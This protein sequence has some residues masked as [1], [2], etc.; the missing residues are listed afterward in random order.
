MAMRIGEMMVIVRAQDFASRTLRRVGAEWGMLSKQQALTRQMTRAQITQARQAQRL[1]GLQR[2]GKILDQVQRRVNLQRT[3][4][5][6][7][8]R[9]AQLERIRQT[10]RIQGRFASTKQIEESWQQNLRLR[11]EISLLNREMDVLDTS[12]GRLPSRY[13]RLASSQAD[14]L[15]TTGKNRLEQKALRQE[16]RFMAEDMQMMQQAARALPVERWVRYGHAIS[17]VARTLQLVGAVTTVS[18][19]IAGKT[20]ADFSSSVTL[21]ASQARE[22]DQT[23]GAIPDLA[24]GIETSIL[25]LTQRF[26]ASAQDMSDAA[27]EIFSSVSAADGS[28]LSLAEG[29]RVLA[30]ANK[31]AVGSGTDLAEATNTLITVVNDFDPR[32]QNLGGTLDTVFDIIRFGRLRLSTFN[33]MLNKVAPAARGVGMTLEDVGGAMAYLTQVMPSQR[34]VAT[35]ISRLIGAFRHPD[36][37]RGAKAFK[38]NVVDVRTGKMRAL[39]DIVNDLAETFPKL[40]TGQVDVADMFKRITALGRQMETGRP[41]RGLMFTEEGRRALRFLLTGLDEYNARQQQIIDNTG[42]FGI[43]FNAMMETPGVQWAILTNQVKAFLIVIGREAIPVFLEL[44]DKIAEWIH[45]FQELDP[46]IKGNAIRLV[47]LAGII[48]LLAGVILAPVGA[49][50]ALIAH[51]RLLTLT[52]GAPG[53]AGTIGRLGMLVGMFKALRTMAGAGLVLSVLIKTQ[54]SGDP[55]LKD[56]LMGAIGGGLLGAR[57]GPLGAV[58]GTI[59]VPVIMHFQSQK[60]I[61]E[62]LADRIRKS[63]QD[64]TPEIRRWGEYVAKN[65]ER[66]V[67]EG[68]MDRRAFR[69]FENRFKSVNRVEANRLNRSAENVKKFSDK[70]KEVAADLNWDELMGATTQKQAVEDTKRRANELAEIQRQ[71]RQQAVD[72][73]RQMYVQLES[74]NKQAFGELFQGPWLTSETFDIAK[75]WGIQPRIQDM[76]RDLHEQNLR[77]KAWRN[78]LDALFKRGLPMEMIDELRQMG[79]EQGMPLIDN[80]LKASPQQTQRLINEWKRR[81]QQIK[82]ATKMDFSNEIRQF[83]K[84]GMNMGEAMI[85][86]FQDA[87]VGAWFD[88]WINTN[89]PN[90]I[91]AAVNQA[92][93]DWK[94]NNPQAA[95]KKPPVKVSPKTPFR[96]TGAAGNTTTTHINVTQHNH[97]ESATSRDLRRREA[98]ELAQ[99]VARSRERAGR[100]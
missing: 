66:G 72:N 35:G 70:V 41:S 97:G 69:E 83:Q 82:A 51:L 60:S 64:K 34:Q 63:V 6:L 61:N 19:G 42:E 78:S 62:E 10:G 12:L 2:E 100:S 3:L 21:A 57:F 77:F 89:F 90:L 84:A 31:V 13:A 33:V 54:F 68:L 11:K 20:A 80:I 9:Q 58:A 18:L 91:Q 25:N 1:G 14:L 44:G 40:T 93:S 50:I 92:V 88:G 28:V 98:F 67:T 73:L 26:P 74:V 45:W 36:F 17:G 46:Q 30:L 55:K 37:I 5:D 85:N 49:L 76:I 79:P 52:M 59:T 65:F 53:A 81:N 95:N 7:G 22:L 8:E 47:A 96:P 87:N 24:K 38:I 94:K 99:R 4:N 23:L 29:T 56:F 71:T 75:E 32:M 27:Y 16:M 86:G 15:E 48:T 39:R 43:A